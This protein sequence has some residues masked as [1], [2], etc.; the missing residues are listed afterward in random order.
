MAADVLT[1]PLPKVKHLVMCVKLEMEGS[2]VGGSVVNGDVAA[3]TSEMTGDGG[4][5][6]ESRTT[7]MRRWRLTDASPK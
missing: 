4:D 5:V 6:G 3:S 1:K 7:R 2:D